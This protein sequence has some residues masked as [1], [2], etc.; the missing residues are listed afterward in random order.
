[1]NTKFIK[2]DIKALKG[3]LILWLTQA[4]SALGSSMTSFALIV[5]SHQQQ[6]SAL[7]TAFLSVCSYTPNVIV[8]IFISITSQKNYIL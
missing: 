5:W 3:F 6:G 2:N 1:M 4:F 7:R 8:S